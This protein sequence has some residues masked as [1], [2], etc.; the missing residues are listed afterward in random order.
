[1][2]DPTVSLALLT[3]FCSSTQFAT[4]RALK[5]CSATAS[6]SVLV[7]VLLAPVDSN[8]RSVKECSRPELFANTVSPYSLHRPVPS[9][10]GLQTL[11]Q[12]PQE[13]H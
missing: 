1:M 7:A 4:N 13:R 3:C 10:A 6:L 12:D 11:I 9:A 5:I 8:W 2:I